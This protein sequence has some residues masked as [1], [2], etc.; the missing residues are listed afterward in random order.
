MWSI[1]SATHTHCGLPGPPDFPVAIA[2]THHKNK[3]VD[4]RTQL[5]WTICLASVAKAA[6]LA[7][8]ICNLV[9]D[10]ERAEEERRLAGGGAAGGGGGGSR[11]RSATG[12]SS[13]SASSGNSNGGGG[14]LANDARQS[15]GTAG[16]SSSSAAALLSSQE[17]KASLGAT[18]R[19]VRAAKGK[20][21]NA[22]VD[23]LAARYTTKGS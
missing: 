19:W 4:N 23:D 21:T 7:E 22:S 12:N 10:R 3:S 2:W 16:G 17:E 14:A 9:V 20:T 18:R 1:F 5:V 13:T 11:S 8:S 15:E 6:E